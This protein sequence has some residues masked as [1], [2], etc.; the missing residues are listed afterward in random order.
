MNAEIYTKV[1]ENTQETLDYLTW[2]FYYR[3]LSQNPNYYGLQGVSHTHLSDKLSELM[4]ETLKDLEQAKAIAIEDESEVSVLNA[5][6]ISAFYY[7]R[8][9][10]IELFN[11]SLTAKT[12]MR[13][14]IEILANASEFE[15]LPIRHKENQVL[16]KLAAHLPVKIERPDYYSPAT[17]VNILLQC[18]FS[19]KE[20]P[21]D[22]EEDQK[23]VLAKVPELLQAMVDIISSNGWLRPAIAAMELSQMVV[24]AVWD[25][26]SVFRQL[27]HFTPDV[28]TRMAKLEPECETIFDFLS[29]EDKS[30]NAVLKDMTKKQMGDIA[31]VCNQFPNIEFEHQF[32]ED[33][34]PQGETATL[35]VKLERDMDAATVPPVHAPFFPKKKIENWWLVVGDQDNNTILVVKRI[36]LA[37]A[38]QT[39]KLDFTVPTEP[40]GKLTLSL[41]SDAWIGCD[42]ENELEL[43]V[44]PAQEDI[45]DDDN[46]MQE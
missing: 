34:V 42:Q 7:I 36:P 10:T 39:V 37:N 9:T 11:T 43:K 8:Y 21:I 12:K 29:L 40:I 35:L 27:P 1:I 6:M 17:K 32:K 44:L 15:D 30:R 26:E 41:I 2:T 46:R 45:D 16:Q 19:R 33:E 20:L 24:Q 3:R 13:G 5:G 31:R 4:E 18:H 25:S 28:I 14:L 22:L 38:S 23:L